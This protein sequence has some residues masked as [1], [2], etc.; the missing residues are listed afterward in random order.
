MQPTPEREAMIA[1]AATRHG[2]RPELLRALVQHESG[3]DPNAIGDGGRAIGLC[4]MHPEACSDVGANWAHMRNPGAALDA[5]AAYLAIMLDEFETERTAL[6]AFN[7]GP[8][9][10]RP[11][12]WGRVYQQAG[13]YAHTPRA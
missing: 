7:G 1:A 2:V 11:W 9:A 8:G 10:M 6:A 13:R 3:F 5:G 12:A 4:Q